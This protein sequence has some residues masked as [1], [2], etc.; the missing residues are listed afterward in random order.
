MMVQPLLR[1]GRDKEDSSLHH[2]KDLAGHLPG[3]YILNYSESAREK[4][5]TRPYKEDFGTPI[6]AGPGVPETGVESD[7]KGRAYTLG[8]WEEVLGPAEGP[9]RSRRQRGGSRRGSKAGRGSGLR[10]RARGTAPKAGGVGERGRAGRLSGALSPGLA[11]RSRLGPW[12]RRPRRRDS[13]ERPGS[14]SWGPSGRPCLCSHSTWCS[15]PPR[16]FSL[17]AAGVPFTAGRQA[18][19][20]AGGGDDAAP[21]Q[22]WGAGRPRGGSGGA[23]SAGP[24]HS[25]LG[26]LDRAPP[27]GRRRQQTS[28][29]AGQTSSS[30]SVSSAA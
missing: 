24:P 20:D 5:H 25:R 26:S 1:R 9:R 17:R 13:P 3:C 16:R 10:R 29:C 23:G 18:R 27:R 7:A 19:G 30:S 12:P 22:G 4:L 8:T 15:S 14:A 2:P 28:H 21:G 6:P 11:C